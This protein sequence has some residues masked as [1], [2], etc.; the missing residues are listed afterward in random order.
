LKLTPVTLAEAA[1]SAAI[2][3]G[4]AGVRSEKVDSEKSDGDKGF[5]VDGFVRVPSENVAGV[6]DG[7]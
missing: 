6:P 1:L 3:A 5:I 2:E 4:E 7:R